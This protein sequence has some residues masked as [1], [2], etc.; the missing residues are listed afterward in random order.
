MKLD[1]DPLRALSTILA[2]VIIGGS[3][4]VACATTRATTDPPAQPTPMQAAADPPPKASI[5]RGKQFFSTEGCDA[6]HMVNG[7]GGK[8]GPDLSDEGTK[9]HSREW[10]SVQIR[11]PKKHK[12]NSIM[13]SYAD[14][15]DSTVYDLVSYLLSL[16]QSQSTS[17]E[18]QEPAPVDAEAEAKV[19]MATRAPSPPQTA[20]PSGA[21]LWSANCGRCHNLRSPQEFTPAQWEVVVHHM[22]MRVPLTGEQQSAILQFLSQR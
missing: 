7:K 15:P 13:R 8:V 6:C 14:L 2:V 11:D 5:D 10:L 18:Q 4:A 20:S 22:R 19:A 3:A 12:P 16:G 9:G 21:E 17:A 1:P